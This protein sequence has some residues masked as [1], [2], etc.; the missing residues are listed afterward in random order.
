MMDIALEE[1]NVKL[2]EAKQKF[3]VLN[4]EKDNIKVS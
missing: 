3:R 4:S 1:W 2:H